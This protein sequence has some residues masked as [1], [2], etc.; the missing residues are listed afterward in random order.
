M[1]DSAEVLLLQS[2]WWRRLLA[3]QISGLQTAG[4]VSTMCWTFQPWWLY[5]IS[6]P[7]LAVTLF[8]FPLNFFSYS[9]YKFLIDRRLTW[10]KTHLKCTIQWVLLYSKVLKPKLPSNWSHFDNPP[11]T[12]LPLAVTPNSP[13]SSLWQPLRYFLIPVDLPL[14]DTAYKQN[15]TM[16]DFWGLPSFL[17]QVFK[18]HPC[19]SLYQYCIPFYC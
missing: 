2:P 8:S 7:H 11:K 18:I 9:L 3:V 17:Y 4:V 5:P 6:F 16:C 15:H 12:S 13:P 14:L 10:F 1:S 19:C